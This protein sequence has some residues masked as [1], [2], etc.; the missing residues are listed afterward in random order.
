MGWDVS[1]MEERELKNTNRF[2]AEEFGC[3][4]NGPCERQHLGIY[5]I[6]SSGSSYMTFEH[7]ISSGVENISFVCRL[8]CLLAYWRVQESERQ[9]RERILVSVNS[10]AVYGRCIYMVKLM[11]RYLFKV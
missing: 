6:A 10:W 3:L 1:I 9:R 8:T 5:Y 7:V 11:K 2:G 4:Q